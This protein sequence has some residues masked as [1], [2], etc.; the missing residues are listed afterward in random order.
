MFSFGE[1]KRKK[2]FVK[3]SGYE[4]LQRLENVQFR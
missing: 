3:Y 2:E 4:I 1:L